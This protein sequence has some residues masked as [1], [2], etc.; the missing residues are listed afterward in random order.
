MLLKLFYKVFTGMLLLATF[1]GLSQ[2]YF[3]FPKDSAVWYS[4]Y[5]Y[6]WPHPPYIFY[7]TFMYQA[8][9]DTIINKMEYT[10]FFR[11]TAIDSEIKLGYAGA[12]RIVPDSNRVYFFERWETSER[13]VYDFSLLPGDTMISFGEN[14][15]CIDTSSIILQNGCSHKTLTILV[16][17]F[18]NCIQFWVEG[19]GSMGVPLYEPYWGCGYTFENG[20]N[21]S[22]FYY[23]GKHLFEWGENPYFDGC[24]GSNVGIEE[25]ITGSRFAITPNPVVSESYLSCHLPWNTLF[26]YQ[27]LDVNGRIIQQAMGVKPDELIIQ[28]SNFSTGIYL[29]RLFTKRHGR[30]YSIK[31]I[32][33]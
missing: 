2:E 29:L 28:K 15:I 21:L 8:N 11:Y 24:I 6:P 26:D 7:E 32:I 23:K 27:I 4:V 31:F 19:V 25:H 9:G 17:Y 22:C 18:G 20:Y 14:Y 33:N 12:Y 13:L 10:K 5:S 30:N 16:P 1:N 3:P